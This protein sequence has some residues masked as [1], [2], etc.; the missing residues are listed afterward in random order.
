MRIQEYSIKRGR[1]IWHCKSLDNDQKYDKDGNDDDKQ[2]IMYRYI[3]R[4]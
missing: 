2:Q 3:P 1:T 4:N